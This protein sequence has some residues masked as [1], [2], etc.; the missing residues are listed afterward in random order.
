MAG[1]CT[2]VL[3]F[4]SPAARENTAT[5]SCNIQPYC[6]LTHQIIYMYTKANM[7][8]CGYQLVSL[9]QYATRCCH[10][11]VNKAS[12]VQGGVAMPL[13]CQ[14]RRWGHL[15]LPNL[16]VCI[17]LLQLFFFSFVHILLSNILSVY[18]CTRTSYVNVTILQKYSRN[19]CT[20]A[21]SQYQ[22]I[23]LLPRGLG[24]RLS[25]AMMQ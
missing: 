24:T 2:S 13:S 15:H 17:V 11:I 22:A 20:C 18:Y 5:H 1:Y 23:F 12:W 10:L 3:Y 21:S 14:S 25:R 7:L 16:T 6:L 19:G 9:S 8:S 4:H